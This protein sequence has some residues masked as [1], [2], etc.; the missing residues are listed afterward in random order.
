MRRKKYLKILTVIVSLVLLII[1]LMILFVEPGVR[2]KIEETLNEKTNKYIFNIKKVHILPIQ[3]GIKIDGI[4]IFSKQEHGG[5]PDLS[6]EIASVKFKRIK[7]LKALFKKDIVIGEVTISNI[8]V[9]G[10]MPFHEQGKQP[11]ILPLNIHISKTLIEKTDL[12]VK[13]T[14]SSESYLMKEGRFKVYDLNLI[15]HDTL[16]KDIIKQFDFEAQELAAVMADSMYT[17]TLRDIACSSTSNTLSADSFSIH[18][19]Y[20]DYEFTSRHKFQTV[21]IEAVFSNIYLHDFNPADYLAS[22]SLISSYVEIRTMDMKVFRDKRKEFRHVNRPVFQDMIYNY[23]GIIRFDSIGLSN[24][25]VTYKVHGEEA[26][27]PGSISFN[28]IKAGI[29][30]ITN[31]PI[32][33]TEKDYLVLKAN[34]LLMGKSRLTVLLK[35]RI[36]ESNNT[37]T[38]DGT[39]SELEAN[40]LNPILE[41]NAFVYITSGK[42]D[43]MNFSFTANNDKA[44][45]SMTLL[46]HGLDIAV[47][48][49]QSDDTTAFREKFISFI[50]NKIVLDSNPVSGDGVRLGIID[51]ERDPERFLFGYCFKSILSGISSSIV[52]SPKKRKNS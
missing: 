50:A 6:G 36:F 22:G 9:E 4:T 23:P 24:G 10:K 30:K 43:G 20:T 26:N 21:R 16:S 49:K 12:S 14:I 5:N 44:T 17:Y 37:F 51:Y 46:Y 48:N 38:L 52:K 1:L 45:G 25:N 42:I 18:P 39:L 34:A 11:A 27:E 3:S 2:K 33:K 13:N 8:R 41:N 19:N 47:K 40:E 31:D 28:E 29:Y 32:Y 15:K 7:I 35:G